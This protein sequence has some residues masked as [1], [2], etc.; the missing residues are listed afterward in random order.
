MSPLHLVSETVFQPV[1]D[2]YG[3]PWDSGPGH[4]SHRS[5]ARA[6]TR[7]DLFFSGLSPVYEI[8]RAK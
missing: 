1:I 4:V 6:R 3:S 7:L 5:V 2:V 8:N